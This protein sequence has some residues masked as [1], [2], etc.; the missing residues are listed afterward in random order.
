MNPLCREQGVGLI[1][2]SPLGGGLLVGTRKEGTVR[3]GGVMNRDRFRRPEDEAVIAALA[4]LADQRGERPAPLA[5]AWLL[6]K[7]EMTAPI[8]GLTK[9]HHLDD[10]LRA[11]EVKLVPEEIKELEAPYLTQ[12]VIGH[13]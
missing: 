13:V 10:A 2:Y 12:P 3:S 4:A 7:P 5:L 11:L 8:V 6:T 1:P 9:P